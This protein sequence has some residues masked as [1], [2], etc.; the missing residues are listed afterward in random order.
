MNISLGYH[1]VK[2]R[3]KESSLEELARNGDSYDCRPR[4]QGMEQR[5]DS[6]QSVEYHE[7]SIWY[8]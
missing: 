3:Q 4:N 5:K 6:M 7:H 8:E 2:G 1:S